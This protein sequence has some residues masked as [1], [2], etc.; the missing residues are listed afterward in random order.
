MAGMRGGGI[1]THKRAMNS[2]GV[3]TRWVRPLRGAFSKYATLPS[4]STSIRS[5]R[6]DDLLVRVQQRRE[7]LGGGAREP[8]GDLRL[9]GP[10]RRGHVVLPVPDADEDGPLR[11]EPAHQPPRAL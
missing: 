5:R 2:M 9:H 1:S 7:D 6:R 8:E 10:P 3:I 4:R 11:L